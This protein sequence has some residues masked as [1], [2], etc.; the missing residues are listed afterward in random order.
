MYTNYFR[1]RQLPFSIAPDPRY[2][3][4]SERHREALAHLLYGIEA[5]GGIVLLTGEIG[6]GKTTLCRC[7]LEQIPAN[8]N[9][10]YVFNPRLTVPELLEAICAEFRV[11]LPDDARRSGTRAWVDA[12]NR[13]LLAQHAAGNNNVLLIDEAQNLVPDVLEQLR[14]LTNLETNERKLLQIILIGQPELRTMLAET[15]LEQLAQRVIAHYHLGPLNEQE[16]ASYV[17]HRLSVAGLN[18]PSPFPPASVAHIHRLSAGV[19]RRINLLCDRALLGAY[20]ERAQCI[21]RRI[22]AHAASELFINQS[23]PARR[24]RRW[25][26]LALAAGAAALVLAGFAFMGMPPL[27]AALQPAQAAAPPESDNAS[28]AELPAVAAGNGTTALPERAPET[29]AQ[30]PE[31]EF[32]GITEEHSALIQL[33]ALWGW[34]EG[35]AEPC[36]RRHA[37]PLRCFRSAGGLA[38][39]RQL[40]RPAVL[41]LY[42]AHGVPYF[43]LLTA[44]DASGAWLEAGP[45]RQ[46]VDLAA[47]TRHFR[48]EFTTLWR[49]P[50]GVSESLARGQRG[51]AVDWA[52]EQLARL[53]KTE[54][55]PPHQPFNLTLHEQVRRFQQS[56][57]LS[58][59]GVVG[60]ITFMHLNRVA[61]VAEPVLLSAL[62]EGKEN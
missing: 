58:V 17:Q 31:A 26:P 15:Q 23:A 28:P 41:R 60:P 50:G 11:A 27:L 59:D 12:L 21:D 57:G 56:L 24:T 25:Q 22:L 37:S 48:G 29:A 44:L 42:D 5:G 34:R 13:Y 4:M 14:L 36:D 49:S 61:G 52:G 7:L 3:F 16:T 19:P 40:D 9:V 47:L 2:L 62:S 55:P 10:A 53:H 20:A 6:T 51:V 54:L 32:A 43:A 8:C 18:G 30:V 35:D 46:K 45:A 33:A 1:L 39:L 38:E